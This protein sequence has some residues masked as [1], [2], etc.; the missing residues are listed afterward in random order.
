MP[1]D[2]REVETAVAAV[3]GVATA[4]VRPSESGRARL[5]ITLAP[6][7][8]ADVVAQNVSDLL[9][10]RFG[11]AI[12]PSAIRPRPAGSDEAEPEAEPTVAPGTPRAPSTPPQPEAA[13][14]EGPEPDVR[15][16]SREISRTRAQPS[17]DDDGRNGRPVIRDL[18]VTE[19]GLGV[20]ARVV[21]HS[22]GRDLTGEATAAKTHKATLRAIARAGLAAIEAMLGDR[23]R[24]ELESLQ[25]TDDGEDQQVVVSVAFVTRAGTEKLVGG[26]VVR[27]DDQT[28]ALRAALDAINRRVTN[29]PVV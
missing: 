24:L 6:G 21:L 10:T 9:R 12:D 5:R 8:D 16:P 26:A 1:L 3:D 19:E 23:A 2:H 29:V 4:S 18:L 7:G 20:R 25:L 13:A 14:A 27:G 11:L 22:E 28:A 15:G 17:A